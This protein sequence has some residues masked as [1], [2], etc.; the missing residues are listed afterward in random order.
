MLAVHTTPPWIDEPRCACG[1]EWPRAFRDL[2]LT[3]LISVA[4]LLDHPDYDW[5]D[6]IPVCP[7]C[8]QRCPEHLRGRVAP[9]FHEEE[10]E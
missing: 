3:E 4:V 1:Y 7:T 6:A 8:E 2:E 5:D 10:S 9:R